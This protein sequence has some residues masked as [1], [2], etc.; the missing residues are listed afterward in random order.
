MKLMGDA[1][2]RLKR[3][4][5]DNFIP[6]AIKEPISN[7]PEWWSNNGW[8]FCDKMFWFHVS[9]YRIMWCGTSGRVIFRGR[10][11]QCEQLMEFPEGATLE[12][13]L[14]HYGDI[15]QYDKERV[16]F[17]FIDCRA[18]REWVPRA[19][20]LTPFEQDQ[21]VLFVEVECEI[22]IVLNG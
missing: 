4:K 17:R 18:K 2:N 14:G 8:L 21:L 3:K 12:I 7:Q 20:A 13:L 1:F 22:E 10:L 6:V 5:A 19:I 16:A 9:V 15:S 11:P